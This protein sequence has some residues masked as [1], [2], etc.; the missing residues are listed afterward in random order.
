MSEGKPSIWR[1]EDEFKDTEIGD[2][3]ARI[4]VSTRMTRIM[5]ITADTNLVLVVG[6]AE[7]IAMEGGLE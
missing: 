7:E 6:R 3:F 4:D 1:S 2:G 5:R